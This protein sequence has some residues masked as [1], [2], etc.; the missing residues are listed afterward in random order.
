VEGDLLEHV[1]K[2]LGEV[3]VI[4]MVDG[5]RRLVGLFDEI[6]CDGFVRLLL[7]PRATVGLAQ[8]PHDA[9]ERVELV[10]TPRCPFARTDLGVHG[11]NRAAE[12]P[13]LPSCGIG[14]DRYEAVPPLLVVTL[15]LK[16]RDKRG[17]HHGRSH[18]TWV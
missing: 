4:M 15:A 1:A 6:A 3:S 8:P 18:R 2:L 11:R 16:C 10:L 13:C 5:I 9:H 14:R 12:T 7:V 17:R